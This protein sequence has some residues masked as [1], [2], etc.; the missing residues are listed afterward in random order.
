[1]HRQISAN[2]GDSHIS[3]LHTNL[4]DFAIKGLVAWAEPENGLWLR[5]SEAPYLPILLRV[6]YYS[7]RVIEPLLKMSAELAKYVCCP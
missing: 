2:L 6:T 7:R 5:D 3:H 1:M 4:V